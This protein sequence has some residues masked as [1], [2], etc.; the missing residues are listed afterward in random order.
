[1]KEK[2]T[3][4]MTKDNDNFILQ[5]IQVSRVNDFATNS[6]KEK[7][8]TSYSNPNFVRQDTANRYDQ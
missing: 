6:I 5:I 3:S 8:Q 2:N 4:P 1:M 7:A